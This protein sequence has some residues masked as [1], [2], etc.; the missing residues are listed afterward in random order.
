MT[1]VLNGRILPIGEVATCAVDF[2]FTVQILDTIYPVP[3]VLMLLAGIFTEIRELP[4]ICTVLIVLHSI[5]T[6][7]IVL[8]SIYTVLI[9]LHSI[10]TVLVVLTSIYTVLIVLHSI[11]TVLVVVHSIYTM[12]AMHPAKGGERA[13]PGRVLVFFV[14]FPP[15]TQ[16]LQ[17]FTLTDYNWLQKQDQGDLCRSPEVCL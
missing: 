15:C 2:F 4:I 8:T 10:C 6:V 1:I 16:L 7:L 13:R 3:M 9:V 12:L 14:H 5:C 11:F 17:I